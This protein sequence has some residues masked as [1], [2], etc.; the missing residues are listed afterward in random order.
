MLLER[1]VSTSTA[2]PLAIL[3]SLFSRVIR[4]SFLA[5]LNPTFNKRR[6]TALAL[7]RSNKKGSTRIP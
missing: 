4:Y 2:P 7:R 3:K 1:V 6:A 5:R